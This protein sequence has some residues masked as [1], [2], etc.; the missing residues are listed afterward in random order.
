MKS[1]VT[2]ASRIYLSMLAL[3]VLSL[4]VIG[5]ATVV[6][7][8]KQNDLYHVQ[9]LQRKEKSLI[10]GL[11]YFIIEH[12][13]YEFNERLEH[14]IK[15]LADVH[16]VDMNIYNLQG[17]LLGATN[18]EM[19]ENGLF[20]KELE[21]VFLDSIL[22]TDF[23]LVT[24]EDKGDNTYL[25]TYFVLY[26]AGNKQ[27][28]IIN[29]PYQKDGEQ[30][31]QDLEGF[32]ETIAQVYILLF[33]GGS[34]LAY[35]LS[36]YITKRLRAVRIQFQNVKLTKQ[37]QK[38]QWETNDEIGAIVQEYNN[39]VDEL[40]ASLDKVA[41][42]ERQIA[43]KEMAKQVAHEIKN[44]L[45]PMRLSIQHFQRVLKDN[46]EDLSDRFERFSKNMLDQIDTLSRIATEFSNFAKMPIANK[47]ELSL[48]Q[49]TESAIHIFENG[50]RCKV[51]F[52][53]ENES[54]ARIFA[55]KSQVIRVVNN[56]MQNASQAI[57][58]P[59]KGEIE[60]CVKLTG[61]NMILSVKDNGHGIPEDL[62]SRIFEP[63]FTTKS[64][65]TGLGLAMV[66]NII[67][68]HEGFIRF[69]TKA[70]VGT[71][72]FIEIPIIKQ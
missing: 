72:F 33:V 2:L 46:P 41:Q 71:T 59:E 31:R 62:Q 27:M 39:K 63:N 32:F 60:V 65:G 4:I 30:N 51:S 38:I 23:P 26:G 19:F 52:F 17:G 15:E 36:N 40:A 37:N 64:S 54:K 57:D 55:D 68:N 20:K 12:E 25:S 67:V 44:P 8:K 47:E 6:Y 45:T 14:K 50:S 70:N 29:V 11:D 16:R 48:E 28:A 18:L 10:L 66:R 13:I 43:W 34:A 53:V 1:K 21:Q 61:N 69:E 24:Q 5:L 58:E 56:L 42:S 22:G 3:I 9:R 49:V 7:F 35:L